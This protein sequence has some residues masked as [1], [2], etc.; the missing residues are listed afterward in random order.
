[1]EIEMKL[2]Q[3]L[4]TEEKAL[5]AALMVGDR[6]KNHP[7]IQEFLDLVK[8]MNADAQVQELAHQMQQHQLALQNGSGEAISHSREMDRLEQQMNTLPLVQEYYRV[9]KEAHELFLA[10]DEVISQA[11]GVAFAA[12]AK[13]SGCC[14]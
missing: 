6:L 10:V 5:K 12:N 1:M 11:A 4:D 14:G 13:R 7:V 3:E 2:D 8:K 9:E